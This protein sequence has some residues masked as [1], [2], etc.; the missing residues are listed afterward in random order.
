MLFVV[1]SLALALPGPSGVAAF[2]EGPA[3]VLYSIRC[4]FGVVFL[5]RRV[6]MVFFLSLL[7]CLFVTLYS[8]CLR[9]V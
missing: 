2:L 3:M 1:P 4:C 7:S 5:L 8:I 9:C 6:L